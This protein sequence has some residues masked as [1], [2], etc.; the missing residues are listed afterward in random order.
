MLHALNKDSGLVLWVSQLNFPM[1]GSFE[2]DNNQ[3]EVSDNIFIPLIDGNLIKF[4]KE[5]YLE[6]REL[7]PL[8]TRDVEDPVQRQRLGVC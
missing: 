8:M 6:V 4:D 2:Y 3:K 7:L 1:I 5:G